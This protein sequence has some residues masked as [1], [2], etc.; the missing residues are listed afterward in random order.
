MAYLGMGSIMYM[1]GGKRESPQHVSIHR[2]HRRRDVF[3]FQCHTLRFYD[4]KSIANIMMLT[5]CALPAH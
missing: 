2:R 4:P 3:V 5:A 1:N